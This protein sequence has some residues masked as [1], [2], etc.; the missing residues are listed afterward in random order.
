MAEPRTFTAGRGEPAKPGALRIERM[1]SRRR[2]PIY[3]V[4]VLALLLCACAGQSKLR[5][6]ELAQLMELYPGRYTNAAQV[7]ADVRAGR[8]PHAALE[9]NIARVYAPRSTG[10]HMFYVQE[11]AAED[12]RRIFT[13]RVVAFEVIKDRGIVQTLA[14][15]V[16]PTRWRDAHLNIDLFKSLLPQDVVPMSGCDLAWKKQSARFEGANDQAA[17]RISSS[18]AGGT[19]RLDLRAELSQDE[20]ALCEQSYDLAGKLLQGEDGDPCYRFLRR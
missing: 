2:R 5:E 1:E 8:R 13:Q 9:M 4:A 16:E 14:T 11:S 19:V 15:F 10:K 3:A 6:G 7:A 12:P 20:M 17:C 18:S